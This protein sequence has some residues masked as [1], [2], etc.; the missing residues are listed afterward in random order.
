MLYSFC[1]HRDCAD[2]S[3]AF[4]GLIYVRGKLFGTTFYGG[5]SDNGTVFAFDLSAGTETVIH[6]FGGGMD[7]Q[8]PSAGLIYVN[9]TLYGTTE[10]GG[11]NSG[12]TV[13]ALNPKTGAEKVLYSFCGQQ[14]CA[15]GEYPRASLIAVPSF[16]DTTTKLYGTTVHGG[17][18]G[19]GTVFALDANTG[20]EKTLYSFCQ[21]NCT[22]GQYAWASL[23]N[24][25][26]TLY[27]ATSDGGTYSGGTVFEL[28][29]P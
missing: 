4:A 8:W 21:Q 25:K 24:V 22:D 15:D 28:K 19:G 18:N 20:A 17:G 27:G 23:I 3:G 1:S 26:G 5:N 13:F 7:G 29:N 6:S 2:G 11:N 16:A 9:G 12:G 10:E 14:N